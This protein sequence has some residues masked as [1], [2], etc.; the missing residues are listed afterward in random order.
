MADDKT[1]RVPRANLIRIP[2]WH[3]GK[4]GVT[5]LISTLR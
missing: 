3:R 4:E 1:S 2:E 5:T